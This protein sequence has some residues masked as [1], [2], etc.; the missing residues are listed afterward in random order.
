MFEIVLSLHSL[1]R[2]GVVITGLLVL[3]Q[4]VAGL[5]AG[6]ELGAL[7]K[8]VQLWFLMCVDTQLLLG[9]VLWFVSPTASS[10]RADMGAAMKDHD[11]RYFVVEHG[12]LMLL[13]VVV[14]HVGRVAVKRAGSARS[15]HLRAAIYSAVAL[16]LI[17]L[18]TP[19]PFMEPGRPWIR[20][21]F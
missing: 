19:W 10:A 7:G 9:L 4:G 16:A 1:L 18:R 3:Q 20:L 13:A 11:L 14:V 12:A 15:G 2:W 5:M 21:P 6:G 8:R 17:A